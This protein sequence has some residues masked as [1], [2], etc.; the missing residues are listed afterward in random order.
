MDLAV[1]AGVCRQTSRCPE[2]AQGT[3]QSIKL[4]AQDVIT[5]HQNFSSG[6]QKPASNGQSNLQPLK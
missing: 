6:F 2:Q 1:N 3:M 5:W 4:C